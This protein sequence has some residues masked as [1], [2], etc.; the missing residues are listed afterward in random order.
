MPLTTDPALL[1]I[2]EGLLSIFRPPEMVPASH[3]EI[4]ETRQRYIRAVALSWCIDPWQKPEDLIELLQV[5]AARRYGHH[6]LIAQTE[7]ELGGW[8]LDVIDRGRTVARLAVMHPVP[9]SLVLQ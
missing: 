1:A 3:P 5:E 6:A 8:A 7:P 2:L 4:Q 9:A